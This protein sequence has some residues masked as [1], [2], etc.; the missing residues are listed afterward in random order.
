MRGP[1]CH[2]SLVINGVARTQSCCRNTG[3]PA[4][5]VL[6][7]VNNGDNDDCK[8]IVATVPHTP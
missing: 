4:E 5:G 8:N 1:A 6:A 3:V 2:A 7:D